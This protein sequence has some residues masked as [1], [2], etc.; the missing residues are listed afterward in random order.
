LRD[1]ALIAVMV[2]SF[3][4]ISAVVGMNV[5]D[6]YQN[7]KRYWFRLHEK[8]G[9]RIPVWRV[10]TLVRGCKGGVSKAA[11]HL[12][13]PEAKVKA[14]PNYAEAFPQE[15]EDAIAGDCG[16]SRSTRPRRPA[17]QGEPKVPCRARRVAKSRL[18]LSGRGRENL[19]FG[20][21]CEG[22]M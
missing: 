5:E 4:R 13:W 11:E 2:Y 1:R 3:A 12:C 15:I 14:A 10:V 17:A 20:P 22:S 7:G 18:C 9:T 6:F 21:R 8:G 16:G 19:S